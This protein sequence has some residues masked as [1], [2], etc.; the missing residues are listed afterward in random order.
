MRYSSLIFII[1]IGTIFFIAST[2]MAQ[3]VTGVRELPDAFV[4]VECVDV[5]I[6]IDVDEANVPSGLIVND[7]IPAGWTLKS[8]SPSPMSATNG[9]L[10][11]LFYG[12]AVTDKTLSYSICVPQWQ[13]STAVFSGE[14]KYNDPANGGISTTELITGDTSTLCACNSS[15]WDMKAGFNLVS[16]PYLSG[17]MSAFQLLGKLGGETAVSSIQR[18]E[19]ATGRFETAGY[20]GGTGGVP[21]GVNFPVSMGEGY[22]IYMNQDLPGFCPGQ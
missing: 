13:C 4:S 11:W 9:K 17:E 15:L 5:T 14:L 12:T 18:F 6:P 2:I 20:D 16:A 21:A 1:V 22:I 3:T 7:Y 8:A 10:S 19:P